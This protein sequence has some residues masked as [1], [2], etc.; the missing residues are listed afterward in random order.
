MNFR[1]VAVAVACLIAIPALARAQ[2]LEIDCLGLGWGYAIGEYGEPPPQAGPELGLVAR[3]TGIPLPPTPGSRDPWFQPGL[4]E[5]TLYVGGVIPISEETIGTVRVVRYRG[6]HLAV[7]RDPWSTPAEYGTYPPNAT[8]PSAFVDGQ[9]LIE[10]YVSD[11]ALVYNW[12]T[13]GGQIFLFLIPTFVFEESW[14]PAQ[15][16]LR[17]SA[18]FP[19]RPA[20]YDLGYAGRLQSQ[21]YISVNKQTGGGSTGYA[22]VESDSWA[23]VKALFR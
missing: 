17:F 2:R 9:P 13:H 21:P 3:I 14:Y 1:G 18:L 20:G 11:G 15:L 16:D 5:Y 7:R 22:A 19:E 12:A 6:G 8:V 4:Y 23:R 10:A